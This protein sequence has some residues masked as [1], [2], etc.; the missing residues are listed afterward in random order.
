VSVNR[1]AYLTR[2]QAATVTGVSS[3]A[4]GKWHARGW[5]TPDGQ[6]RRLSYRRQG[7]NLEFRLGDLFDAN[8]DTAANPNSRRGVHRAVNDLPGAHQRAR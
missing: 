4:I 2:G 3:D 5:L 6:R 1:N 7:R 8:R